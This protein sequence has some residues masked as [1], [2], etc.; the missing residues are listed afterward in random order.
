ME[1][2]SCLLAIYITF[3][4]EGKINLS[5]C[6]SQTCITFDYIIGK[7]TQRNIYIAKPLR[8]KKLVIFCEGEISFLKY[9]MNQKISSI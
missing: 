7:C 8:A 5:Q 9:E 4:C 1:N 3:S 2:I 6:I